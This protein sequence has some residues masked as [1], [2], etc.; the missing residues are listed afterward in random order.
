MGAY[1]FLGLLH[2]G[3]GIIKDNYMIGYQN[4]SVYGITFY[5]SRVNQRFRVDLDPIHSLHY[6]RGET[7]K[8]RATH[9]GSWLGGILVG[10]YSGFIGEVY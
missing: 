8:Q 3:E 9:K 4:P 10:I 6:H 1:P 5:A 2:G 7:K